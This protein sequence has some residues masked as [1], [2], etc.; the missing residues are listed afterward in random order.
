MPAARM[1]L[2]AQGEEVHVSLWPGSSGLT[3]V[4]SRFIAREGRVFVV[5]ASGVLRGED[6]PPDFPGRDSLVGDLHTGGSRVVGPDGREL[7]AL[8]EPV[9]GLLTADL[10]AAV[11]W[12]ERQN[13]DPTGHYF[14]PDVFRLTV[15]RRR[16]EGAEFV[17]GEVQLVAVL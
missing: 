2:Y 10:D 15:D 16:G 13:F 14:R 5:A 6:V 8:D 9:E 11:L 3:R 12:A 1:S 7:A 4:I 17:D